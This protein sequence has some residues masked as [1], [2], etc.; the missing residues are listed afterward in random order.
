MSLTLCVRRLSTGYE[1]ARPILRGLDLTLPAGA[2][3]AVVGPS[4]CGKSTFLSTVAGFTAPLEG[5]VAWESDGRAV[6]LTEVKTSFVWQGLALFPWK[7]VWETLT[8][9]LVLGKA[10]RAEIEEKGRAMLEELELTGFERRFPESLSGGQRQRLALGRALISSP[11]VLFMDEP[12]SALDALL[13]E[14]LQ[15]R[16][17]E[18]R[19][20]HGCTM[21]L[22]THDIAEA[23]VLASHIL[24]LGR[25]GVMELFENPAYSLE[26]P[27][28]ESEDYFRA[29]KHV[30]ATLRSERGGER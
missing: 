24:I 22:V 14:R 5:E 7:R 26:R 13:R 2:S 3:L 10:P 30:H 16:V 27:D 9:P 8:L 17:I 11:D 29:L 19:R 4:G 25:K 1:K 20:R 18:L 21:L 28:R 6:P 12:F 15:D 23:V